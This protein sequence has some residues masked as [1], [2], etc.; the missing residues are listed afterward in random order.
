MFDFPGEVE[1]R[2][3]DATD[4]ATKADQ[5]QLGVTKRIFTNGHYAEACRIDRDFQAWLDRVALDSPLKRGTHLIPVTLLDDVY[6][7]LDTAQAGYEAEADA[8]ASEYD[9]AKLVARLRLKE[10]YDENDY[11]SKEDLRARF[12][13]ERQLFDF[14]QPGESKLSEYVYEQEKQRWA[15]SFASAEE[16]V[17]QALRQSCRDLVAHLADRLAPT[18]DGKR[19]R[20]HASAV[21]NLTEFLD[22]FDKRNV[23]NDAELKELVDRAR[24]VLNG[25]KTVDVLRDNDTLRDFV[26]GQMEAIE[27]SLDTLITDGPRR[28]VSFEED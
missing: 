16:E 23:L 10:L 3:A 24:R 27:G 11:P 19:K 25:D 14:A 22:L 9:K 12:R 18:A 8:L 1:V 28:V 5:S 13:V 6:A 20:L 2:K 26:R 4:S 17:R 21:E 15:E 7:R